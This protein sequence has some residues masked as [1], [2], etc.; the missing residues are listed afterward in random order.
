MDAK[1]YSIIHELVMV[2]SDVL[3]EVMVSINIGYTS[4]Y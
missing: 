2:K 3:K 1:I 4:V